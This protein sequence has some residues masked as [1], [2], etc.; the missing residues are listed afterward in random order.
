M[1]ST[2]I[3]DADLW[4]FMNTAPTSDADKRTPARG[5]IALGLAFW[6]LLIWRV[7]S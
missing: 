4:A 7:K 5:V 1:I 6:A 2:K 3:T